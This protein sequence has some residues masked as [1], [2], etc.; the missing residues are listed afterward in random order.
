MGDLLNGGL[1]LRKIQH[2]QNSQCG[3]NVKGNRLAGAF[4]NRDNLS[5][6]L[7]LNPQ[8]LGVFKSLSE[9][10]LAFV[11]SRKS[12]FQFSQM[13]I[14]SA[15]PQNSGFQ[16]K[17]ACRSHSYRILEFDR[18]QKRAIS[19]RKFANGETQKS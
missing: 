4:L 13:N 3:L 17:P 12:K 2:F 8:N 19:K 9:V 18:L 16:I 14:K 1:R 10:R 6:C 7:R 15:C 11:S 5:A